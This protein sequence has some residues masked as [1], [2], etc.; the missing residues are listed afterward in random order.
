LPSSNI[1]LDGHGL[2]TLR[3]WLASRYYRAAFPE[4]F[5]ARLREVPKTGKK[6]FLIQIESILE[7]GGKHIRGIFFDLDEGQNIER[8]D[9]DDCYSLGIIVLNDSNKNER[10]SAN[11]ADH[12]AN[13]LELLFSKAFYSNEKKK[14]L[15]IE[16]L[17]CDAISDSV[18]T[19]AQQVQLRE[20]RL[21]HMSLRESPAQVMS[22]K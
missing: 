21:E 12:A 3:R 8:T 9:V 16:L 20:W 1:S 13:Q 14:W 19:V 7:K 11:S 5:E 17:Y 10:D 15:G 6:T 2:F 4:S 18:L 22:T